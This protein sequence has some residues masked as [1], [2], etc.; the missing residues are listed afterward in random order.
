MFP[1]T[2][3]YGLPNRCTYCRRSS[4]EVEGLLH[5]RL[6]VLDMYCRIVG[7]FCSLQLFLSSSIDFLKP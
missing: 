4:P 2:A 5:K 7:I 3:K 1:D 6:Y